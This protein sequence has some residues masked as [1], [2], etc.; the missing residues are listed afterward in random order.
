V[1][2]VD[3]LI[4]KGERDGVEVRG[5]R[6]V[7]EGRARLPEAV[8]DGPPGLRI[9]VDGRRRRKLVL[10]VGRRGAG[11][12]EPGAAGVDLELGKDEVAVLVAAGAAGG[13]RRVRD[14][15]QA[16]R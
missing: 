10:L 13:E 8:G 3:A 1:P 9:S 5:R 11:E 15:F 14:R 2:V 4:L 16:E 12:G 6:Q 7:E